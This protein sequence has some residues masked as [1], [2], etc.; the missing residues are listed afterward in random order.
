MWMGSF[1]FVL[2]LGVLLAP[3][4]GGR[5]FLLPALN[6]SVGWIILVLGIF[7]IYIG[8]RME[9]QRKRSEAIQR[10]KRE[11]RSERSERSRAEEEKS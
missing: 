4:L 6:I 5:A 3:Y 1:W 10:L 2:G 11:Q 7:R 9:E 8:W